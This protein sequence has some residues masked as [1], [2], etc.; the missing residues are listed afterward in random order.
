MS[1]FTRGQKAKLAGLGAGTRLRVGVRAAAPGGAM[2]VSC[3]GVDAQGKLSDERYFVFYNQPASPEGAIRRAGAQGGDDESFDVELDRL[4]EGIQR[5]VFVATLDG[6]GTMSQLGEGHLRLM[7]GGDEAARFVFRGGDFGSEKALILG[8][9]YRKDEWRFAAVGQGFSGGLRALLEHFGGEALDEPAQPAKAQAP[10]APGPSAV[11]AARPAPPPTPQAPPA[12]ARRLTLDKR[13]AEQ[14]PQLV[15]LAKKAQ[16]TL[17]KKGLGEHRARVALVLDI[18]GSM[19]ALYRQGKVQA[20]AERVLALATRFDDDGAIDVFLFGEKVHTAGEMSLANF[21]E[22][23]V[24]QLRRYGL[25]GG[26]YYGKAM[27][28][29]RAHYFRGGGG[30]LDHPVPARLP[31]YVMFLTDGATMDEA[32]TRRQLVSASFQPIFWQFM[33]LGRSRR[34]A[35][36]GG[37]GFLASALATDFAFLEKLDELPGRYVDNAGFFSVEDPAQVGDEELYELLMG[38][39]PGWA[40]AAPSRGLVR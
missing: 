13:M 37:G 36:A 39:Y 26:T 17:E 27:R 28:A 2:D 21:Q 6:S 25:E 19:S 23:V 40:R 29:V 9:L 12:D 34:Q 15:S 22:F 33:G 35:C 14:A 10:P 5:L 24:R 1:S 38:E 18:S 20:L 30:V 3:F 16:L 4:P 8:E 32:E 11:P 31:V 7:A